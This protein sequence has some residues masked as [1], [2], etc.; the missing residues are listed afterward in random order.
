MKVNFNYPG[1]KWSIAQWIVNHFPEGYE[2]MIYLE[3]FAGSLA[4][5]FNKDPSSVEGV[6]H[7]TINTLVPIQRYRRS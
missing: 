3:P 5:F 2:R 7:G 4:V 1:S 6:N